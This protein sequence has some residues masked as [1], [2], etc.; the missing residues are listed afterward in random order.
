MLIGK[1]DA[2]EKAINDYFVCKCKTLKIFKKCAFP[3]HKQRNVD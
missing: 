2:T 3:A 1:K